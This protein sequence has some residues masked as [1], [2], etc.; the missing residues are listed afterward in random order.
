MLPWWLLVAA[1]AAIGCWGLLVRRRLH[2]L[3]TAM[4]TQGEQVALLRSRVAELERRLGA[5]A[6]PEPP[7][8]PTGGSSLIQIRSGP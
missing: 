4:D 7:S 8:R 5:A 3:R 6:G 2:S 1:L